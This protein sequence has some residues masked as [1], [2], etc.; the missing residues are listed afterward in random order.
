MTHPDP[1]N[2]PPPAPPLS[3]PDPRTLDRVAAF[4]RFYARRLASSELALREASPVAATELRVLRAIADAADLSAAEL[5]RA[6][7]LDQGYLSRMLRSLEESGMIERGP[8]PDDARRLRLTLSGRGREVLDRLDTLQRDRITRELAS[9]PG[10]DQDR[11][12]RSMTVVRRLLAQAGRGGTPSD[13]AAARPPAD[14]DIVLRPPEC[15]DLGWVVERHGAVYDREFGW[16]TRFEALVAAVVGDFARDRD[17]ARE[18]CWI[19]EIQRERVGSVFLVRHRERPGVARLRLLLV[20]PH[21]RGLS[22]G[23]RLV[24]ACNDFAR[25]AGYHT[26]TLWTNDPLQAARRIYEREGYRLVEEA[27]HDLFGDGLT[28]QHWELEL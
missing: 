19:A 22:I 23:S 4:D 20:E 7:G 11:L 6:L 27:P 14:A 26:I 8:S 5:A 25:E 12:A 9:L 2:D 1:D 21:A 3:P 24:R 17:P 15:G 10:P 28:G 16:G 18:R 13:Q